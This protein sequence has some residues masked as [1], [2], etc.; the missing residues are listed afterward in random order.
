MASSANIGFVAQEQPAVSDGASFVPFCIS[1]TVT[2]TTTPA[3]YAVKDASGNQIAM[4]RAADLVALTV[5]KTVHAGTH[6]IKLAKN[7]TAISST[8]GATSGLGITSGAVAFNIWNST[9][10][11]DYS[12][13]AGTLLGLDCG[14]A[15]IDSWKVIYTFLPA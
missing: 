1:G 9:V 2:S 12:Y 4:P 10:L 14:S 3:V 7:G 13:A 5:I 6:T 15:S 8:G 11:A